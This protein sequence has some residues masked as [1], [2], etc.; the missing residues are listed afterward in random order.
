MSS[1]AII[2]SKNVSTK[3]N[4][5]FIVLLVISLL[6][7]LSNHCSIH[8][9]ECEDIP[10]DIQ[11]VRTQ[12]ELVKIENNF[13]NNF[14]PEKYAYYIGKKYYELRNRDK[15]QDY[16][17][18]ASTVLQD[19]DP[20]FKDTYL[21]LFKIEAES[22]NPDP[23]KLKNYQDKIK[24]LLSFKQ[25]KELNKINKYSEQTIRKK[26]SNYKKDPFHIPYPVESLQIAK[27]LGI[28]DMN[29]PIIRD[30]VSSYNKLKKEG[31]NKKQ[32]SKIIDIFK[33]LKS[34]EASVPSG[35]QEK[36]H[37]LK[38]YYDY[39]EQGRNKKSHN[40]YEK[41]WK[42]LRK[43]KG[44]DTENVECYYKKATLVIEIE[45]GIKD[46]E[47]QD[48]DNDN[49]IKIKIGMIE[50]WLGKIRNFDRCG[51]IKIHHLSFLQAGKEYYNAL[52]N[53]DNNYENLQ[54]FYDENVD[55]SE[56]EKWVN[57]ADAQLRKNIPKNQTN[58]SQQKQRSQRKTTPGPS[59]IQQAQLQYKAWKYFSQFRYQEAK[60]LFE[61]LA[62]MNLKRSSEFHRRALFCNKLL[63]KVNEIK[64]FYYENGCSMQNSFH[65]KNIINLW[66]I[67]NNELRDPPNWYPAFSP[68]QKHKE[69][70][71][72]L[73]WIAFGDCRL[74]END[75]ANAIENYNKALEYSYIY[76]ND[77]VQELKEKIKLAR[78]H[79]NKL[80]RSENV[81]NQ[82]KITIN[83]ENSRK[84]KKESTIIQQKVQFF[85]NM[86]DSI[87]NERL[88]PSD[89]YY[90]KN[91]PW[92]HN[93]NK[94]KHINKDEKLSELV[95]QINIEINEQ[96]KINLN[97]D[98]YLAFAKLRKFWKQYEDYI[99]NLCIA[100]RFANIQNKI[101]ILKKLDSFK[102]K[103]STMNIDSKIKDS[104]WKVGLWQRWVEDDLMDGV[105]SE[106]SVSTSKKI[107]RDKPQARPKRSINKTYLQD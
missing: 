47:P 79:L 2:D 75:R 14:C 8:A 92:F 36:Y 16:L 95:S 9:Y 85:I 24:H 40:Y 88:R 6:I 46:I 91:F 45:G 41:A 19:D 100:Y 66:F 31:Q 48:S 44:I 98:L 37:E 39:F 62:N 4:I 12:Q 42:S 65:I 54:Q 28:S 73:N 61:N 7:I 34:K 13:K 96:E 35:E 25:K 93:I 55:K 43:A 82:S 86:I 29:I 84:S 53:S 64:N 49:G 56:Y 68:M 27:N 57:A 107:M 32:V 52:R 76:P 18:R 90:K 89:D 58:P 77:K 5:F 71:L 63:T 60:E 105:E 3:S 10:Y 30:L 22:N 106:S 101:K 15:A 1:Q 83:S 87:I 80:T 102:K 104:L 21:C 59:T 69:H 38:N 67:N 81:I 97:Y 103:Y 33:T 20:L 74:N 99:D 72:A 70:L 23:Y 11:D 17:N 78:Q 51:E 26:L 94:D 50:N